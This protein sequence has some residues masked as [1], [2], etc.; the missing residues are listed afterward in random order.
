MCPIC[1]SGNEQDSEASSK[2]K[3]LNTQSLKKE[4]IGIRLLG[5]AQNQLT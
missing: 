4:N 3:S 1:F 2:E 5:Q